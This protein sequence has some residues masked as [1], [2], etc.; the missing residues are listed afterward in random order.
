MCAYMFL[1]KP[2]SR[3]R[4]CVFSDGV[5]CGAVTLARETDQAES[6]PDFT[7]KSRHAINKRLQGDLWPPL[8][9]PSTVPVC[10]KLSDGTT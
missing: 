7:P 4:A 2:S 8:S 3:S 10:P 9:S 5:K 6:S 1:L